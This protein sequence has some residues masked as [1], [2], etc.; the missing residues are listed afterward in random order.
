MAARS[1]GL[2][3]RVV[4]TGGKEHVLQLLVVLAFLSFTH[5]QSRH[6]GIAADAFG[7]IVVCDMPGELVDGRLRAVVGEVHWVGP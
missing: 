6:D 7:A 2:P 1:A 4:L 3:R 5:Y